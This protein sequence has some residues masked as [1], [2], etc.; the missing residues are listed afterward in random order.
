MYKICFF[1]ISISR[2]LTPTTYAFFTL[3]CRN[4]L[5]NR[6]FVK[7]P[8]KTKWYQTLCIKI[9][10]HQHRCTA[11]WFD[12]WILFSLLS[13]LWKHNKNYPYTQFPFLRW[14]LWREGTGS[15]EPLL[16]PVSQLPSPSY[17]E[18]LTAV[19]THALGVNG[20]KNDGICSSSCEFLEFI[21]RIQLS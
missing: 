15:M 12:I 13:L 17:R 7:G 2:S 18:G 20:S 10:G 3:L 16:S 19:G 6:L 9:P 11:T 14:F 4:N 1:S 21:V 8:Y 5:C